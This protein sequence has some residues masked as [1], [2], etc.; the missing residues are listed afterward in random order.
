M[1]IQ[2]ATVPVPNGNGNAPRHG[3]A[4][5]RWVLLIGGLALLGGVVFSARRAFL[6]VRES[7]MLKAMLPRQPGAALDQFFLE[8][9]DRIFVRYSEIVGP[10]CYIKN[11]HAVDGED[12]SVQ[13]PMRRD[14]GAPVEVRLP[15]GSSTQRTE[16]IAAIGR[17]GLIVTYPLPQDSGYDPHRVYRLDC[18]V[19]FR[20][21]RVVTLPPDPAGREGRDQDGI[22]TYSLP[23][24]RRFEVTYRGGVP[25]GPFRAFYA[26]GSLW[27]EATY[28]NGRVIEAW[29][30]TRGSRRF[31][32]L[33]QGREANEALEAGAKATA[34][35][36]AQRGRRKMAAGDH[37]GA[38]AEFTARLNIYPSTAAF[39]ERADAKAAMGDFRGAFNDCTEALSYVQDDGER[40]LVVQKRQD[41]T[42]RNPSR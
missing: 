38:L 40:R 12:L 13:F 17:S 8:N 18:G 26:D 23:D 15:D 41:L 28:Q 9:R 37:A 16:V 27:G 24:G 7:S 39:L 1:E 32:E 30:L 2:P 20:G 35:E 14:W 33:N 19:A 36:I 5:R 25:D 11:Y 3:A 22:H 31:D 34:E 42:D 6:N 10:E 4:R 29:V 21:H